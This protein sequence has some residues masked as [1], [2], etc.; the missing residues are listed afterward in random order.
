MKV[1]VVL[2]T[3]LA[4]AVTAA[5]GV[6]MDVR[7]DREF[8]RL[9]AEG[10]LALAQGRTSEA[11]EAF[12][13]ALAFK[14]ESMVAH[15][16]RG[17]T[18]RRRGDHDLRAALRDAREANELDPTAPQP[19]ELLGDIES[20]LGRNESAIAYYD[21][22]LQLDDHGARV[23]YKLALAQVKNGEP[24]LAIAP[25]GRAL[26]LDDRF[27]EAR[28]LLGVALRAGGRTDA[29]QNELR[30]AIALKGTLIPARE[31][32]A[33]LYQ[34]RGRTRDA[35]EQLEAIA[36]LEPD[37]PERLVHVASLYARSGRHDAAVLTLARATERHP[38]SPAVVM[39]LG[40]LWI[41]VASVDD[42]EVAIAKAVTV[43]Q[44]LAGSPDATSESL[45]LFGHA[46]LM[47]GRP[48]EAE[49]VL[50][51]AVTRQ[52]LDP[53]AYRYLEEAAR[54]LGHG[55]L[56]RQAASRYA[57]FDSGG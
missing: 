16:K 40:R 31:E 46:L 10:D 57:L 43:L 13:G 19:L 45:S 30:R 39:A 42:D 32:L 37:E 48:A 52:P 49:R 17:E 56:A 28:Y 2:A 12:S 35:I 44:P 11:I 53:K 18:Y 38:G 33:D 8:R 50:Q 51:Q 5:A 27:A 26:L 34:S 15:L 24:S 20:A 29:A 22:C 14:P 25:L 9:L 6:W 54:R 47:A 55:T 23:L 4:A 41:D 1:S 3:A 36:A 7:Q 21:R